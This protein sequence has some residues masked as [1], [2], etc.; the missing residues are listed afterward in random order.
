ME[1]AVCVCNEDHSP[2]IGTNYDAVGQRCTS[3]RLLRVARSLDAIFAQYT[4]GRLARRTHCM[5]GRSPLARAKSRA[6]VWDG[7]LQKVKEGVVVCRACAVSAVG[8][9]R[10][11]AMAC[12]PRGRVDPGQGN[13]N[14]PQS[15]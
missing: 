1:T 11:E 8:H 6:R 10:P 5:L 2:F 7:W 13:A 9:G 15:A 14:K 4:H 3:D 12:V